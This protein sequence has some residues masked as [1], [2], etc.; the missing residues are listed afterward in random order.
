[1]TGMMIA[2]L[3]LGLAI[4]LFWKAWIIVTKIDE[5]QKKTDDL[6]SKIKTYANMQQTPI[7][8]RFQDTI[9]SVVIKPVPNT[10]KMTQALK[11]VIY[12]ANKGALEKS[13][14]I[15][16]DR[17]E[18][19]KIPLGGKLVGYIPDNLENIARELSRLKEDQVI[20]ARAYQNATL[21]DQFPVE[22]GKPIPN[23]LIFRKGELIFRTTIDG[24][25]QYYDIN[26]ELLRNIKVNVGQMALY[27][28]LF[29]NLDDGSVGEYNDEQLKKITEDIKKLNRKVTVEFCAEADTY[30]LGPLKLKFSIKE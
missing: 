19:L 25:K 5:Y 9:L 11:E 10:E 24:T 23:R 8:Y 26:Y 12:Q 17:G 3:T 29:P 30:V 15:A 27:K 14:R 7:V 4:A 13:M 28:G 22:L 20:F 16:R 21:G 1:L 2:G 18:E 6:Q